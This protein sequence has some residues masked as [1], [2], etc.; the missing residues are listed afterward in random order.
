MMQVAAD[1]TEVFQ[2]QCT[3]AQGNA[4]SRDDSRHWFDWKEG[5]CLRPAA[6]KGRTMKD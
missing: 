2:T 6:F 1:L 3:K 5:L 4:A